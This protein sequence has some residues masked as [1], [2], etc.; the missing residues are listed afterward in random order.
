MEPTVGPGPR[1]VTPDGAHAITRARER[2]GLRSRDPWSTCMLACSL[3]VAAGGIG[4]G[5]VARG[6][7]LP[8]V[9]PTLALVAVL[10]VA[11]NRGA[12]FPTELVATAESAVLFAA[13]VGFSH[14][15]ALLGPLIVALAV[16][17][18]DCF[19]WRQRA[20]VRMAYNSGSQG[21][22]VLVA[23]ITFQSVSG[24]IGG[25]PLAVVAVGALA[26]VPYAF[27]D[28]TC[29]I[30]LMLVRGAGVRDAV[31]HQWSLNGL[32]VPFACVG[33][34]AGFLAIDVGWWLGIAVLLPMP[35]IPELV[36]VRARSM[37]RAAPVTHVRL[38]AVSTIAMAF[39]VAALVAR[40]SGAWSL[41]VL[42][43][44][45]VALGAELRVSAARAI[46]PL[47]AMAVVAAVIVDGSDSRFW[48]AAGVLMTAGVVG[49]T[50]TATSWALARNARVV[51]ASAAI[52]GAAIGGVLCGAAVVAVPADAPLL[53]EMMSL[54][55]GAAL[56]VGVA[57]LMNG[58]RAEAWTS[59]AWTAP[60]L[61]V[62]VLL[63]SAWSA[64]GAPGA[65]VFAVV[66][67]LALTTT[68]CAAAPAWDS[69]FLGHRGARL[70]C[71]R[72]RVGRGAGHDRARARVDGDAG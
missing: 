28:S 50:V 58:L 45:A 23:A 33:A 54:A 7:P 19:H 37:R 59:V 57:F 8:P 40:S 35:W 32:A 52:V 42:V 5:L 61:L 72:A 55:L 47:A 67:G 49:A 66:V 41:P 44:F 34:L 53:A 22:A 68:A 10:A 20:F 21:L 71:R 62:A 31:R 63:A 3:F 15:A 2:R 25:S 18:L 11:V 30:V 12:F 29:G 1:V 65:L 38:L 70:R 14:D 64:L 6:E 9:V 26:A 69:R 4:V 48:H 51:P 27:V 46:P 39:V 36:L 60:L 56:F 16:G 17:P 13:L 24:A 43:V